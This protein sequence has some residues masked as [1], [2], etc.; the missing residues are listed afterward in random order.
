MNTAASGLSPGGLLVIQSVSILSIRQ[1]AKEVLKRLI[2]H[3]HKQPYVFWGY[4]RTP[5]EFA[6]PA[7]NAGFRTVSRYVPRWTVDGRIGNC[8]RRRISSV[9]PISVNAE[10]MVFE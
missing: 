3:Y 4:W 1:A 6:T 7:K 5:S 8:H 10:V 9:P 2:G